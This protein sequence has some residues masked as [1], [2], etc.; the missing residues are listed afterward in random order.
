MDNSHNNEANRD[1]ETSPPV[2]PVSQSLNSKIVSL[3]IYI[4]F[5]LE[6]SITEFETLEFL[7]THL[8]PQ[9]VRFSSI[10]E[11]NKKGVLRWKRVGIRPED[12]MIVPTFPN[13][14]TRE[15]YDEMLREYISK[16]GCEN[17]SK[18]KPLW[19][20]HLVKYPSM[21]GASTL[22]FKF[23]HA[24]GDGY[25]FMRVFFKACR[26]ADK[27]SL[28]PTFP[29]MSLI[30]TQQDHGNGVIGLGKKLLGLMGT[31]INTSY[32]VVETSLRVTC[33]EDRPS[34]IRYSYTSKKRELLRPFNVYSET[35]SLDRVKQVRTKLGATVN[36]VIIGLLSYM[37]HLYT[38]RKKKLMQQY[39]EQDGLLM[40]DS[41]GATNMTLCV[42]VNTR[43]F[44]GAKNLDD[45]IKA[46]A[47]GNRSSI[48]F[49]KL[50]SFPNDEQVNPLDFIIQAK[51]NMDRKKNSLMLPL[52]D[53][54]LKNATQ[55]LGQKVTN[56]FL[57]KSFKNSS[58]M[59]SNLIGPKE[60][61]A[62]MNHPVINFYY[63]VSGIPQST[64]FTSMTNN[65][66]LMVVVT[67]EKGFIDSELFTSCMDEAFE[68][69]FQAAFGDNQGKDDSE[70]KKKSD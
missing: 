11:R 3:I 48:A 66:K 52:L 46:E 41:N 34:A 20:V 59:I 16:I 39:G 53:P 2:S 17:F 24:I 68:N 26:R 13:G 63:I 58:T 4:V 6:T 27:P 36:D 18:G 15:R 12:H 62:F 37:I 7:R 70:I 57:Y 44:K 9:N 56:G 47:W 42:M 10:M 60:Q 8:V 49:A 30:K 33:L 45:M 5:Q 67:M 54:F 22:I 32:D 19:E 50:P 43:V 61:M 29:R 51:K 23:T 38:E 64:T 28:P 40:M 35:V 21:K 69:I 14:L 31:C 65:D 1:E 25:S 55:M